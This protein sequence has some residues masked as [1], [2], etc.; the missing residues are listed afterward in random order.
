M[1]DRANLLSFLIGLLLCLAVF[2]FVGALG[3]GVGFD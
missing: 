3:P 1:K 2:A